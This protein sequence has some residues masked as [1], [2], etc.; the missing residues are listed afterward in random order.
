MIRTPR[1]LLFQLPTNQSGEA[2]HPLSAM[3]P[4]LSNA[5]IMTPHQKSLAQKARCCAT[6]LPVTHRF[7]LSNPTMPGTEVGCPDQE[8]SKTDVLWTR[9]Q[10]SDVRKKNTYETG[11]EVV[12]LKR[13]SPMGSVLRSGPCLFQVSNFV[14]QSSSSLLPPPT[15]CSTV[16]QQEGCPEWTLQPPKRWAGVCDCSPARDGPRS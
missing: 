4:D 3:L 1:E 12:P 8:L 14:M 5:F 7:L 6:Q 2:T 11:G 9:S 16:T 15:S 13:L 10:S